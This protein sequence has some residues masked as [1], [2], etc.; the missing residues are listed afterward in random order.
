MSWQLQKKTKFSKFIHRW[1]GREV[2]QFIEVAA[3]YKENQSSASTNIAK[4]GKVKAHIPSNRISSF[5]SK[6]RDSNTLNS[7]MKGMKMG[8]KSKAK[9]VIKTPSN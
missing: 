7:T 5:S 8:G 2:S 1:Q 6:E 4:A 3:S 9:A